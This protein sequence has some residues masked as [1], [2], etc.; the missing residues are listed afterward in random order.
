[1]KQTGFVAAVLAA[2]SL[3]FAAPA[4]AHGNDAAVAIGAGVVGLAIGAA[5]AS[6]NGPRDVYVNYGD[7]G[8]YPPYRGYYAPPPVYRAYPVHPGWRGYEGRY[9]RYDRY[10]RYRAQQRGD[11]RGWRGW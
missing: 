5:I 9:E 7:R 3:A 6:D 8:Y 4:Q 10:R 11:Y 2:G 1:M